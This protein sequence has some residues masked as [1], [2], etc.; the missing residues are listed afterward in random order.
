MVCLTS[1]DYGFHPPTMSFPVVGT[2][3]IE[4]TESES[5]M[6]LDR[7]VD[8]MVSIRQEIR[9][10]VDGVSDKSDNVLV[11]SPHPVDVLV[12]N[13]WEH[14]YSREQ[15]AYPLGVLRDRKYWPSVS[16]VD[17]TYGDRN[18]MCSCPP[19]SVYEE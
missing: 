12:C 3:M 7:F 5:K 14:K 1:Q 6:E 10:V 18:L 11:N 13:E 9:D 19:I 2:L 4:P 15:A 8:A 17:D 16:R